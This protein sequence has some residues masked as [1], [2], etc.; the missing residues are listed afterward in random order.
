M[1]KLQ[2]PNDIPDELSGIATEVHRIHESSLWS[3]QGQFVLSKQWRAANFLLGVPAA[4]LAGIAG[5]KGLTEKEHSS[6]LAILALI[7]AG[8]TAALTVLNPAH[9]IALAESSAQGYLELQTDSRQLL[10]VDL[11]TLTF[12]KARSR[13]TDLTQRRNKINKAAE[14]PN[15]LARWFAKRTIEG[16]GQSYEADA[17]NG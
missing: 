4:V 14:P 8:F 12:D 1:T 15:G 5:G 3:A 2:I 9:H 11:K 6:V 16:G 17:A 10:T 7:A 13:L